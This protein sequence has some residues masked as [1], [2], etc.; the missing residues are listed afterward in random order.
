MKTDICYFSIDLK[1]RSKRP[2]FTKDYWFFHLGVSDFQFLLSNS[3]FNMAM[4]MNTTRPMSRPF[5]VICLVPVI[6]IASIAAKHCYIILHTKIY[7]YIYIYIYYM[8]VF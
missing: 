5:P 8:C 2:G 7:I 6:F 1:E 4:A 3:V